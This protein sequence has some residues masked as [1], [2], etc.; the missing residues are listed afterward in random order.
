MRSIA[1][2]ADDGSFEINKLPE[3]DYTIEILHPYLGRKTESVKLVTGDMSKEIK[4]SFG[5]DD[6]PAPGMRKVLE[7]S[8][9]NLGWK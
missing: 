9:G 5:N 8:E 2:T 1:N 6:L 3:G 4:V 7:R